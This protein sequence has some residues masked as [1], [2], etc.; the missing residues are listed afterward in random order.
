MVSEVE[1]WATEWSKATL[2]GIG[3]WKNVEAWQRSLN[4]FV[5]GNKE[6]YKGFEH[7]CVMVTFKENYPGSSM[8]G[9]LK[10]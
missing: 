2:S 4:L 10:D 3:L 1:R 8:L 6:W 5:T 9:G 7:Q